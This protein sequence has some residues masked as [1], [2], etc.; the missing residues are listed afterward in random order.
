MIDYYLSCQN[1]RIFSGQHHGYPQFQRARCFSGS[2]PGVRGGKEE[3][4]GSLPLYVMLPA[5]RAGFPG[6][7]VASS[8]RAKEVSFILCPLTPPIPLWRDGARSG[9]LVENLGQF[10]APKRQEFSGTWSSGVSGKEHYQEKGR[11]VK[12]EEDSRRCAGG[13]DCAKSRL[14]ER[15]RAWQ[16]LHFLGS[17]EG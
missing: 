16:T 9:Q 5:H 10:R 4:S 8:M 14:A 11:D 6:T 17:F 2:L 13:P 15:R 7:S 12:I 3:P 1:K